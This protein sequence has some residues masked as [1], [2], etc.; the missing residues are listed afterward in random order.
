MDMRSLITVLEDIQV[1]AQ[2]ET[3]TP[4]QRWIKGT[5]FVDPQGNPIK[6]YHGTSKDQD[7][8]S[9]KMN[10][11]GIWFTTDRD[12]ASDYALQ[13][14]SQG[15]KEGPNRQLVKTHTASRVIPCFVRAAKV[16]SWDEWPDE[17][18]YANNYKRAQGILF[19]RLRWEGYDAI[20]FNDNVIVV[21]GSPNQVKSAIGNTNFDA[22]KKNID[23]DEGEFDAHGMPVGQRDPQRPLYLR[24][25]TWDP[26]NPYSK[27][28]ALGQ[29]ESGLSAYA[30][31]GNKPVVPAVGEWAAEDMHD[32]L[33][34]DEPKFLIQ[35]LIV[36]QGHDGEPLIGNPVVVGLWTA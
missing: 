25:G 29:V 9:F 32:R 7:F 2:T 14:D 10:K 5:A 18:R 4:L 31:K 23:E 28:Y 17:I 1:Q 21:I 15:Y 24:V 22:S 36:G 3:E 35:G 12:S 20:S 34:S 16:M 26:S 27:N 6:L 13:N 8:R 11:N 33:A 19:D 30:L